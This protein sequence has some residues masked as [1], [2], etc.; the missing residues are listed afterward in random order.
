MAEY[1]GI[2]EG[3]LPNHTR[4]DR[5]VSEQLGFFSRSQCRARNLSARV[6]GIA[7]KLSRIIK[8]GDLLEL[9]WVELEPTLI[10][11]EDLPLDILYEDDRVVVINKRQGI[12]VHPGAGNYSGTLAN[13]LAF[14]N[15]AFLNAALRN[16]EPDVLGM[17]PGIVHRLD[18][19]TSGVIIASYD[20][21]AHA[22]LADQF[23]ARKVRKVYGALVKGTPE[24]KRGRI[25]TRLARDPRNRKR[26]AI[27]QT[28]GKLAISHYRVVKSWGSYSLLALRPITG[29]THQ[30]R[31]H[32]RYLGFPI[33]G[34][35]LYGNKDPR[36]PKA[37]LMLHSKS[38]SLV[39]PGECERRTFATPL[40]KR[41]YRAIQLIN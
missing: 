9:S 18:K 32:M 25:S 39:L 20:V 6:N 37:T 11:P 36:V 15:A 16:A 3:G 22:L 31:V 4:L 7:V 34:D 17:R 41:F 26:F 38:L 12:V 13:A 35:P 5:Y 23:K 2:V 27:S 24:I 14:R 28:T 19:D 33:L 1:R 30:L 21:E 8:S 29:R 10:I 40:P